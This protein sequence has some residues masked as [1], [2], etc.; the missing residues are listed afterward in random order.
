MKTAKELMNSP[1]MT[2]DASKSVKEA[3]NL[4][5]EKKISSLVVTEN[6]KALGVVTEKDFVVKFCT[7]DSS[8]S[9]VKVGQLA[10][11]GLISVR[12]EQNIG[13]VTK[14]FDQKRIRHVFVMEN[15]KPIGIITI[16]DLL[17]KIF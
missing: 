12:P 1:V 17:D 9:E 6:D 8:T 7:G 13:E 3:A 11:K 4:M 5:T 14:M 15:N 16:K 10:S 2:I